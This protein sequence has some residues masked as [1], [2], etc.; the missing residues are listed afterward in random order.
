M[1]LWWQ[2][3]SPFYLDNLEPESDEY[4][5]VTENTSILQE[6][7]DSSWT[8]VI[9]YQNICLEI[10]LNSSDMFLMPCFNG[11]FAL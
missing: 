4:G 1:Y 8:E 6:K 9:A 11:V 7:A 2:N 10:L 5:M 3:W